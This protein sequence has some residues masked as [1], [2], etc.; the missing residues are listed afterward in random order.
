MPIQRKEIV[1]EGRYFLPYLNGGK[2]GMQNISPNDLRDFEK[3]IKELQDAGHKIPAPWK[4]TNEA[5]PIQKD[6]TGALATSFD[7][8]GFWEKVWTERN[9]KGKLALVG[10]VDA[11]GSKEEPESPYGRIGTSV[12]DTSICVRDNWTD[13]HGK[14]WKKPVMHIALC[15]HPIEPGQKNFE[16]VS[17]SSVIAMSMSVSEVS[18][19]DLLLTLRS[20]V[21]V[22]LP[23]DTNTQNFLERLHVALLQK[24]SSDGRGTINSPPP[25][26]REAQTPAITMSMSNK[27]L[28]AMVGTTNPDT[29]KPWTKEEIEVAT[30]QSFEMSTPVVQVTPPTKL[31]VEPQAGTADVTGQ[32]SVIMSMLTK[33]EA[34]RRVTRVNALVDSGRITEQLAKE[35]LFPQLAA[36]QMSFDT[37]DNLLPHALDA[38]L[39]ILEMSSPVTTTEDSQHGYLQHLAMSTPPEGS[40][41]VGL[42]KQNETT[43]VWE[44]SKALD[45]Q[46]DAVFN[47]L[48]Q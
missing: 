33:S 10:Y 1:T 26:A 46:L 4:H 8:G 45:D 20:S 5:T 3:S 7:N 12:R 47:G 31:G 36:F 14:E 17:G 32:M 37:N 19:P 23:E 25:G 21:G 27:Q 11:P 2:G 13:G 39:D 9:D 15:T 30:G 35:K 16:P 41:V 34:E 29:T 44:S 43:P 6:A 24:T 40:Q 18:M 22:N 38:T 28:E 42:P 48:S